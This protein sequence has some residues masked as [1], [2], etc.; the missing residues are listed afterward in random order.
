MSIGYIALSNPPKLS[1]D[2]LDWKNKSKTPSRC[3]FPL[4]N[5]HSAESLHFVPDIIV[6]KCAKYIRFVRCNIKNGGGVNCD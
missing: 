6:F 3:R 2:T 1:Q 5:P 4:T